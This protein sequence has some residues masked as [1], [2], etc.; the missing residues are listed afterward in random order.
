MGNGAAGGL[1]DGEHFVAALGIIEAVHPGEGEEVGDLP[2]EED[3][4]EDPRAGRQG[5]GGG[6]PAHHR[7]NRADYGSDEGV[8]RGERFKRRVDENVDEDVCG[9]EDG[10]EAVGGG[11]EDGDAGDGDEECEVSGLRAGDF[12]GGN[13]AVLGA[14][15]EGVTARFHGLIEGAGAGGGEEGAEAGPQEAKYVERRRR[16][17]GVG[18]RGNDVAE[19]GGDDDHGVEA[20]F[21]EFE[22]GAER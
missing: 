15:H 2:G 21:G 7:G 16:D 11:A 5:A 20:G 12:T 3:S 4:T 1:R 6:G 10:G 13:G 8:D 19:G 18:A 17:G 9:G 22:I 14:I